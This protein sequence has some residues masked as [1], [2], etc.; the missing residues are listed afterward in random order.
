MMN[1][2]TAELRNL[3]N[4]CAA[5]GD[6]LDSLICWKGIAGIERLQVQLIRIHCMVT[7]PQYTIEQMKAIEAEAAKGLE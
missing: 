6:S 4:R 5:R 2:I 7:D 3:A 1:A